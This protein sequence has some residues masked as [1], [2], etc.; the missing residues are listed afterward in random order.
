MKT[1]REELGDFMEMLKMNLSL[2]ELLSN[3][4]P[5]G[6]G[7]GS[8][9]TEIADTIQAVHI[10]N[11]QDKLARKIQSIYEFSFEEIIPLDECREIA[12]KLLVI[13]NEESCSL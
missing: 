11:D 10:M 2:L 3:W 1:N 7:I 13:K 4:D 12:G 6:Y 8:Y 5:L 9:D